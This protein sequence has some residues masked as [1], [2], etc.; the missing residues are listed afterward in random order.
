MCSDVDGMH[1]KPHGTQEEDGAAPSR[2][3]FLTA[4]TMA[5]GVAMAALPAVPA[6][7]AASADGPDASMTPD[8][9]LA[10]IV[11]GNAR[12]VAGKP[13]AHLQDLAIIKA[14]A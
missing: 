6:M 13:T 3:A 1:D 5:G 8:A 11:A 10:E 2:R 9:A 7:A 12:F 14:R 4:M